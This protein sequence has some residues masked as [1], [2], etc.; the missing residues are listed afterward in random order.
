MSP[1]FS[2]LGLN[3]EFVSDDFLGSVIRVIHICTHAENIHCEDKTDLILILK[4]L[5]RSY[6]SISSSFFISLSLFSLS[7]FFFFFFFF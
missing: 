1:F 3:A 7:F 5:R 4:S 6:N 2:A